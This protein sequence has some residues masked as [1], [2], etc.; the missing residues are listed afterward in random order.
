MVS[1]PKNKFNGIN[2]TTTIHRLQC[3][4]DT[5]SASGRSGQLGGSGHVLPLNQGSCCRMLPQQSGR[6]QSPPAKVADS[7]S[8]RV[9]SIIIKCCYYCQD[10][11][12]AVRGVWE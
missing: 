11:W 4:E 5:D 1:K 7:S 12:F 10:D 2:S 8:H 9:T 3:S 6:P